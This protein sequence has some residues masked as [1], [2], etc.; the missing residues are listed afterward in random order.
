MLYEYCGNTAMIQQ[1]CCRETVGILQEYCRGILQECCRNAPGMLQECCM[2]TAGIQQECCR[3]ISGMLQEYCGNAAGI[4]H[5]YRANAAEILDEYCGKMRQDAARYC[6]TCQVHRDQINCPRCFQIFPDISIFHDAFLGK[7]RE[8][9]QSNIVPF[10]VFDL[11]CLPVFM[12]HY[13]LQRASR[14]LVETGLFLA[15]LGFLFLS[16]IHI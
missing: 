12:R 6:Q 16:L 4:L 11:I 15:L 14:S 7:S 9:V 5:E 8:I 1:E 13:K 10:H 3:N 2:N